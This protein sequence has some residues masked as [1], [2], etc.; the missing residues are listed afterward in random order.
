MALSFPKF[1]FGGHLD[2]LEGGSLGC[3]D[4]ISRA[5]D[6]HFEEERRGCAT[7]G[8]HE[9]KSERPRPLDQ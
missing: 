4:A 7:G 6:K 1:R 8:L 2:V 3:L 9:V 5:Q